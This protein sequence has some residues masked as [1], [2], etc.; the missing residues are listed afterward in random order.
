MSVKIEITKKTKVT[1]TLVSD[2][3]IAELRN[4]LLENDHSVQDDR[5]WAKIF[6]IKLI[7]LKI[8]ANHFK[9]IY[10]IFKVAKVNDFL[11]IH[12]TRV[13]GNPFRD[14]EQSYPSDGRN[15]RWSS[16]ILKLLKLSNIFL[17]I[18]IIFGTL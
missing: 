6:T 13:I 4:F 16:N 5:F 14:T 15:F 11:A 1:K 7:D 18:F 8:D 9:D 12:F 3:A 10:N 17:L 2:K